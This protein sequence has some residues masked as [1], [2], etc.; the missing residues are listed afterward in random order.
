VMGG[1]LVMGIG[2]YL[3]GTLFRFAL[4]RLVLCRLGDWIVFGIHYAS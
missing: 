1:D 2:C 3:F 4:L